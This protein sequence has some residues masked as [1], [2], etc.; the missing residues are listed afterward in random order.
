[1]VS[2]F[3]LSFISQHSDTFKKLEDHRKEYQVLCNN[4]FNEGYLLSED[5]LTEKLTSIISKFDLDSPLYKSFQTCLESL[6]EIVP[7]DQP[8]LF[9]LNKSS[10]SDLNYGNFTTK[11]F[12]VAKTDAIAPLIEK[13]VTFQVRIIILNRKKIIFYESFY[14]IYIFF[15]L[16]NDEI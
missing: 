5:K 14:E 10:F 1:M 13:R 7:Y 3:F 15:H 4:I 8:F 2:I 9:S 11:S 16:I 6:P 12:D